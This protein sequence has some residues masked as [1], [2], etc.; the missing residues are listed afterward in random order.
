MW[1]VFFYTIIALFWLYLLFPLWFYDKI[2]SFSCNLDA[3]PNSRQDYLY[4]TDI[5]WQ[6]LD[7]FLWFENVNKF[8]LKKTYCTPDVIV[9]VNNINSLVFLFWE[10]LYSLDFIR[11]LLF[12]ILS[13]SPMGFCFININTILLIWSSILSNS[14]RFSNVNVMMK[15]KKNTKF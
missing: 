11:Y 3:W 1:F 14:E 13:Y 4:I 9:I 12:D 7:L 8:C 2:L 6:F 10:F 15:T 5:L